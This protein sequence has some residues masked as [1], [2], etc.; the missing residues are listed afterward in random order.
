MDETLRH[1]GPEYQTAAIFEHTLPSH[2]FSS[3]THRRKGLAKAVLRA[4]L[5]VRE[6]P[7][8]RYRW[9]V[10]RAERPLSSALPFLGISTLIGTLAILLTG[11]TLCFSVQVGGAHLGNVQNYQ[12]YQ[13]AVSR[14]DTRV[15][16]ILGNEY[17]WQADATPQLTL[18]E[19]DNVSSAGQLADAISDTVPQI[20]R[21]WVLT[22]DGVPIVAAENRDVLDTALKEIRS[23]YS[24]ENTVSV[25]FGNQVGIISRFVSSDE[26]MM[27]TDGVMSA[28]NQT[29]KAESFYEVCPGDTFPGIAAAYS[30]TAD[31]LESLNPGIFSNGLS[32]GQL[33]KVTRTAPVLSVLTVENVSYSEEIASPIQE[34]SDDTLYVGQQKVLQEGTV[35][36]AQVQ[37]EVTYCQGVEQNRKILSSNIVIEPTARIVAVGTKV[38]PYPTATGTFLWPCQGDI[39]SPFGYRNIFGSSSFHSGIDLDANYD[40]P[41]SAADGGLVTF[42]GYQG[43]YGNLIIIN[44]GNG[45]ETYYAHCSSTLVAEGD[46]VSKGQLIANVGATGRATGSHLHFETHTNGTAVNP[47]QYL[48]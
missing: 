44:H 41:I 17:V 38:N 23:E 22:L 8:R 42:S 4:E 14:V 45:F 5:F 15:S 31:A 11:Y 37:A 47:E 16:K 35:G 3:P 18:T 9:D 36:Q 1:T 2:G 30:M 25:T 28:L 40:D 39:S 19:K 43:S 29:S 21:A 32:A 46:M 6:L 7:R 48:P 12:D 33:I 26:K 10:L 27:T 13:A 24:T 34:V 20:T